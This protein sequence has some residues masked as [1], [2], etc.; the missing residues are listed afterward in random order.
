MFVAYRNYLIFSFSNFFHSASG[1]MEFF[2]AKNS[3]TIFSSNPEDIKSEK[4]ACQASCIELK[5]PY[6]RASRVAPIFGTLEKATQ[7][8]MSSLRFIFWFSPRLEEKDNYVI[9]L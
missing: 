4:E 1:S 7:Y 9:S 8:F 5:K 3:L 2:S 6:N